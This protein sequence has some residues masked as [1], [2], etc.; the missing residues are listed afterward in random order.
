[1]VAA[2]CCCCYFNC[3]FFAIQNG[4]QTSVFTTRC[5]CE[6]MASPIDKRN[7]FT[8]FRLAHTKLF[9]A[10]T[11]LSSFTHTE[12]TLLFLFFVFLFMFLIIYNCWGTPAIPH[13]CSPPHDCSGSATLFQLC[14]YC[15]CHC[16]CSCHCSHCYHC[17]C[18]S[19]C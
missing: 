2:A 14:G 5:R 8:K 16:C 9:A 1:M 4:R 15:S 11:K 19:S 13:F 18:A 10:Q 12:Y 7:L 6:E 3:L 17:W